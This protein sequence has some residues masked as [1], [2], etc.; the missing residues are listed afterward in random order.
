MP[1]GVA[2]G[3]VCSLARSPLAWRSSPRL[4]CATLLP[5][6]SPAMRSTSRTE[7]APQFI[8]ACAVDVALEGVDYPGLRAAGRQPPTSGTGDFWV[9]SAPGCRAAQVLPIGGGRFPN[10]L[11]GQFP[12]PPQHAPLSLFPSIA[13]PQPHT[14]SGRKNGSRF[15]CCSGW[16]STPW[17]FVGFRVRGGTGS[18]GF[19]VRWPRLVHAPD[20]AAPP[21]VRR[22]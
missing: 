18:S 8:T 3:R 5:A 22:R 17:L 6:A 21:V 11:G 16:W 13:S 4:S 12:T 15:R 20:L 2:G 9:N 1:A 7:I 10:S 14:F 19:P